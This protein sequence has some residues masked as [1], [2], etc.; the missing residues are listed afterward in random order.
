M[1]RWKNRCF[2]IIKWNLKMKMTLYA[3]FIL[4]LAAIL[5][6]VLNRTFISDSRL[7]EA[8]S[9]GNV[10]EAE[11][12]LSCLVSYGKAYLS[13]EDKKQL[14]IY[15]AENLGL[16]TEEDDWA[17][18]NE[19]GKQTIRI[20]KTARDGNSSLSFISVGKETEKQKYYIHVELQLCHKL[21][22]LT[23]YKKLLCRCLEELEVE[24]YQ[25]LLSFN[26]EYDGVLSEQEKEEKV[27]KMMSILKA[28]IISE[29]SSKDTKNVYGYTEFLEEY[30]V[31]N[32]KRVNVNLVMA[33]DEARDKTKLY[34][35]APIYNK[36][37]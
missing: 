5:Q 37:Y 24:E 28:E 4:S 30:L 27:Q 2:G 11:G 7:M 18:E 29:S 35:A 22:S 32:Q 10:A 19:E 12:N 26:G 9:V 14:L 6:L 21:E 36:D 31:V 17:E 20:E 8:F 23:D 15:L 33:Y 16:H 25:P 3:I 34:L 13:K 1:E